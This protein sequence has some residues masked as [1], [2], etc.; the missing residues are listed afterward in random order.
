MKKMLALIIGILLIF[1]CIGCAD[2]K[3]YN[4]ESLEAA[5]EAA[6]D[7]EWR[8]FLNDY[9]SWTDDYIAFIKKHIDN[10]T[11]ASFLSEYTEWASEI[12][13]W[14]EKADKV[15]AGLA[16][17][18]DALSEYLESLSLISE[19]LSEFTQGIQ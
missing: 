8:Q 10:P 12:S 14:T 4:I 9:E 16:D 13:V 1:S 6:G 2:S 5:D 19:K 18:P 3:A 11:D 17:D 15:E 7:S